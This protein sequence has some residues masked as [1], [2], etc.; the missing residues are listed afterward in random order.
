LAGLLQKGAAGLFQNP[1]FSTTILARFTEEASTHP[2]YKIPLLHRE[3]IITMS[4][5]GI[6]HPVITTVT[7]ASLKMQSS[8]TG[9]P[10][11]LSRG[12]LKNTI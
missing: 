1:A 3:L 5:T 12:D 10:G 7:T 2:L 9:Y 8:T 11:K 6:S 4:I